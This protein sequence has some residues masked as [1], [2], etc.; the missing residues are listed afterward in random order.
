[1]DDILI[2]GSDYDERNR[3]VFGVLERLIDVPA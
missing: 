2:F 3:R 1:M